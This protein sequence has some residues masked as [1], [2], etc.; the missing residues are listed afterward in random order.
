MIGHD[1]AAKLVK[2][3]DGS[4]LMLWLWLV[5]C[6]SVVCNLAVEGAGCNPNP[7]KGL[8]FHVC[9]KLAEASDGTVSS[10][11]TARRHDRLLD[12]GSK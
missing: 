9:L 3:N 1:A 2:M 6:I 11:L 4:V 10:M 12:P 7:A 8:I 5:C